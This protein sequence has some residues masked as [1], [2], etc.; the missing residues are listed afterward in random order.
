MKIGREAKKKAKALFRAC[1]AEGEL[2]ADR[3]REKVRFLLERK[4]RGYRAIL[5]RL[6]QLLAH[7][8]KR[9]TFRVVSATALP[10]NAEG[11]FRRL[12]DRFGPP[13]ARE[14]RVEPDLIGGLRLQVGSQL[15][16]GSIRGRLKHLEETL[17]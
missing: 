8:V 14:Y 17:L 5:A 9:R 6:K 11:I 12:E 7:E 3:F 2:S 4:P 10:D 15:W 16:D 1:F 13:L